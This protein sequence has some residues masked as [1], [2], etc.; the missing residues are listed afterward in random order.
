MEPPPHPNNP[1]K[2]WVAGIE[3]SSDKH[4]RGHLCRCVPYVVFSSGTTRVLYVDN[5]QQTHGLIL[6]W[7][8]LAFAFA[9]ALSRA[10]R[11]VR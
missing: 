6:R 1:C 8:S 11:D 9:F 10:G 5:P 7:L 2:V 4:G 3:D